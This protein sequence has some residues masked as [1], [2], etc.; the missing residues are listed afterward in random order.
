[1]L[2]TLLTILSIS[3]QTRQKHDIFYDKNTTWNTT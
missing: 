3:Q 1:M 2:H